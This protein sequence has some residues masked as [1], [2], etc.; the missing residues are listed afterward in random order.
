MADTCHNLIQ[1]EIKVDLGKA[2]FRLGGGGGRRKDEL[3]EENEGLEITSAVSTPREELT[4]S[5]F[6]NGLP[7]S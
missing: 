3:D 6:W 2:L 1:Q 4:R 5:R 7:D